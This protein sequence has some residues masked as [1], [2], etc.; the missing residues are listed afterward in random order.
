MP[1]PGGVLVVLNEGTRPLV[2]FEPGGKVSRRPAGGPGLKVKDVRA[3]VSGDRL[4]LGWNGTTPQTYTTTYF[5]GER[6]R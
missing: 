4:L 1:T 6:R 3:T 2:S 5:L